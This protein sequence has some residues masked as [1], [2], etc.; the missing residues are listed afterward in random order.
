MIVQLMRAGATDALG[1]ADRRV[2]DIADTLRERMKQRCCT[3]RNPDAATLRDGILASMRTAKGSAFLASRPAGGG[4]SAGSDGAI[5]LDA[6]FRLLDTYD[7]R[8]IVADKKA[9][10]DRLDTNENGSLS[11]DELASKLC[12]VKTAPL[13]NAKCRWVLTKVTDNL[14][15]RSGL[16]EFG[17]RQL[18]TAFRRLDENHDGSL[19]QEEFICGLRHCGIDVSADEAAVLFTAFDADQ[20]RRIS[21]DELLRGLRGPLSARRR[22]FI[23]AA[24]AL[25]DKD[26]SGEVTMVDLTKAYDVSKH[27]R[28]LDKSRLPSDVLREFS[29]CWDK[30]TDGVITKAE[31]L[32]YYRDVSALIDKDDYFELMMRNTWHISGGVGATENTTCRRV[33]V[34]F[35][36]G[37]Q[38]VHEVENDLGVK[39]SDVAG[40]KLR[41]EKQGVLNI[42]KVEVYTPM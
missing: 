34:T 35:V 30:N 1:N 19:N 8:G 14:K 16:S 39:A 26:G 25:L 41:L 12:G 10:F 2:T 36:D 28:V 23:D 13:M 17:C 22:M 18:A 15:R 40:M 5:N 38:S 27:P 24:Y 4:A 11:L 33:L 29:V 37:N 6:F 9:L 3:V 7:I 31:F 32:D 42:A 21:R 20:N